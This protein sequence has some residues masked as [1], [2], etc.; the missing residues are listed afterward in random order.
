M[1]RIMLWV[2][3]GVVLALVAVFRLPSWP[4]AR[5]TGTVEEC[6]EFTEPMTRAAARRE[7]QRR[8][9]ATAAGTDPA[10]LARRTGEVAEARRAG[11]TYGATRQ[12]EQADSRC[13][14]ELEA[15]ASGERLREARGDWMRVTALILI[16]AIGL[17][18][19][20]YFGRIAALRRR[21]H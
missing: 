4:T 3:I 6:P 15:I 17:L 21:P 12:N 13:R 14:T 2:A 5:S 8:R 11:A 9:D 18:V 7:L 20:L 16:V 10:R 1:Y 19:A